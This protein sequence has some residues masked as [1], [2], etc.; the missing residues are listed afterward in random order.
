MFACHA[1]ADHF[2]MSVNENSWLVIIFLAIIVFVLSEF[3]LD[4]LLGIVDRIAED[5]TA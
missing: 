4:V 3:S 2:S 5:I 1:L